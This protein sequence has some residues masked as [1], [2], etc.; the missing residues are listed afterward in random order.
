MKKVLKVILII[1]VVFIALAMVFFLTD[2]SRAKNGED[3]IFCILEDEVNDG[4]T[5]IYFG[6]GYKVIH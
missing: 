3:P 4:G 1:I 5:K 2:V 6:L